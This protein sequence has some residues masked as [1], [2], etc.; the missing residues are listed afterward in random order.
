MRDFLDQWGSLR[1]IWGVTRSIMGRQEGLQGLLDCSMTQ[2]R[3]SPP[4][5]PSD[6]VTL[7]ELTDVIRRSKGQRLN[8]H[9]RL[10]AAGCD[11]T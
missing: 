4:L 5:C 8:G 11:E 10:P 7:G 3:P 1:A 6:L 2:R 9:R